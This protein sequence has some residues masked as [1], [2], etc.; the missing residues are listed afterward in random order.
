MQRN[1][2]QTATRSWMM[3]GPSICLEL[4]TCWLDHVEFAWV[5]PAFR[6][7]HSVYLRMLFMNPSPCFVIL[8]PFPLKSPAKQ[9][10][11]RPARG[12]NLA[13]INPCQTVRITN[14]VNTHASDATLIRFP[15]PRH[16]FQW[17]SLTVFCANRFRVLCNLCDHYCSRDREG[18][19]DDPNSTLS[20]SFLQIQSLM[21]S[22]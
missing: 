11:L 1:D 8:P 9:T 17:Y 20:S 7:V 10:D 3:K 4:V 12:P 15:A 21:S 18:W 6:S 16:H 19:R 14:G 5:N 2:W 22:M 13:G